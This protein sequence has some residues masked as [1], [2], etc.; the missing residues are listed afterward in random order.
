MF[1]FT[2]QSVVAEGATLS[3]SIAF[4]YRGVALAFVGIG[5]ISMFVASISFQKKTKNVLS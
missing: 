2:Y 5:S 4:P 3:S 1:F